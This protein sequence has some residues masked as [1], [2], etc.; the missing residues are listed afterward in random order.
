[1]LSAAL[2]LVI[3]LVLILAG[4]S[5]LTDGAS[6]IARR[7]GVSD[8][9]V[10]LTVVSFGTSAPELTISILS[11]AN[12]NAGLAIGNVVGSNIFN[13]CAI[14]GVTALLRPVPVGRG[15]ISNE[16]P[17]VVLSSLV[18]L[19]M[20]SSVWLDGASSA[21]LTRVDG[22]ILLM[23]FAVFM[24]YVFASAKDSGRPDDERDAVAHAMPLW[25]SLA[26]TLGGLAAL[27]WGGDR[28]VDGASAIAGGFG[29]SEAVIGLTIVAVG[30]SLPELATSVM[31]A[32][33]GRTGMAVGNV[34]GSNIFNVFMVL[35]ASATVQ[36]LPF[37][38]IG[39]PDLLLLSA[40]SILFWLSGRIIGHNVIT[41][42]EGTV[43][44]AVYIVYMCFIVA[45]A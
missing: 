25:K 41:R 16:I 22:V 40:V 29:V 39:M 11:S 44:V 45:Y 7:M 8:L 5:A 1:M 21:V 10:G 2:Y 13:I 35:G 34:I 26:Y 32:L 15:L 19:A 42:A 17:L 28:F 43:F 30:T 36:E 18:L 38:G 4:A 31:A 33:K 24:R 12:G 20:G 6:A 23:F 14:I 9:V 37:A 27:I 3:G